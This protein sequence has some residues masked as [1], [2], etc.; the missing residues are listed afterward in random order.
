MQKDYRT[1]NRNVM[2]NTYELCSKINS[3]KKS[4]E[5]SIENQIVYLENE[6]I[7][8]NRSGTFD[9]RRKVFVSK[10]RTYEAASAYKGKKIAVLNFANNHSIGG[11][12]YS[13]GAQEESM[14][15]CST[16]LPCL[17]ACEEI[18]YQPHRDAFS[19]GLLDEYGNS[20]IIYTPNVT[21]FKTDES[22][23]KLLD[24]NDWYNVDV[25]TC[26][27]PE[28]RYGHNR[29]KLHEILFKRIKRILDVAALNK[30]EVLILGAFGCGAFGNPP[31]L[32]AEIFEETLVHFP[33]FETVEFAVF[34]RDDTTNYDVFKM[35]INREY[36]RKI[37][38]VMYIL[39]KKYN[40]KTKTESSFM[41]LKDNVL[42]LPSNNR[43]LILF[44]E[45][46]AQAQNLD[47]LVF[48]FDEYSKLL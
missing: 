42:M 4:I 47:E 13:A 41:M 21:V 10:K 30:V 29:S 44:K 46:V 5:Y 14:C 8:P 6:Y 40:I 3:L 15:R 36:G 9:T 17:E 24:E 31:S 34:T 45:K 22:E 28:V 19:R 16:L 37:W 12:P 26:A 25:I 39:D 32:V 48:I 2:I 38:D 35:Y 33:I 27:A 23:P 1:I 11:A 20:D 43:D 18:F 7:N